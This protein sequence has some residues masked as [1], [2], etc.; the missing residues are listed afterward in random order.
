MWTFAPL[1][2]SLHLLGL[3]KNMIRLDS[4]VPEFPS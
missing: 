4:L 1:S 3:S 2:V